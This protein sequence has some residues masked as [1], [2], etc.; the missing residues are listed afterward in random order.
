MGNFAATK[1]D[2]THSDEK[3]AGCLKD[4]NIENIYEQ[5]RTR[6][7]EGLVRTMSC[8]AEEY[9]HNMMSNYPN[10]SYC[11]TH[12][13]QAEDYCSIIYKNHTGNILF[14]TT[15]WSGSQYLQ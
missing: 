15:N 1:S 6:P 3:N 13:N 12:N 4:F 8:K 7:I 10:G 2:I 9:Y 11:I 5:M 14:I